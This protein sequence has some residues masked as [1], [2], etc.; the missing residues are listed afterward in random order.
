MLKESYPEPADTNCTTQPKPLT[1]NVPE[2]ASLLYHLVKALIA[3][4]YK[5][6]SRT[7]RFAVPLSK[8][9]VPPSKRHQRQM[10]KES[11][12]EPERT[13]WKCLKESYPEP[14]DESFLFHLA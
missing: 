2:D 13:G 6:L 4:A 12:P 8:F 10:V 11:C 9:T 14:V 3:N 1:M 5:A 7:S